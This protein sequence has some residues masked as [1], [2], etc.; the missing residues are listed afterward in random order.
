MNTRK[1]VFIMGVLMFATLV[2]LG[3]YAAWYPTRAINA[4]IEFTNKTAERGAILFARN[5]RLCHGD[6]GEG[7]AAGARMPAAPALN[8]IDL[9]G[10]V[11]IEATLASDITARDSTIE[12][13]NGARLAVGL[14]I[15][16]DDE[17]MQISSVNGNTLRVK[18]GWDHT[19]PASHFAGAEV[20]LQDRDTLKD[21]I[22]LLTNT[23]AC[24]R[25]GTAMPAWAQQHGGPLSDEQIRQLVTLITK[26][27]WDMVEKEIEHEDETNVRLLNDVSEDTISLRVADVGQFS[28]D[29]VIRIG[30]ERMRITGVPRISSDETDRSGVIQV[31]RGAIQSSPQQHA[32][33]SLIFRFPEAPTEPTLLQRSC[34]Q[35][36]R[37]AAPPGRPELIEPFEGQTVEIVAQNIAFNTREIRVQANGQVRLRLDNRDQDI[38]HNIAVRRS[39]TDSTPAS[40]GSVGVIF[41]G[42]AVGDVAF[43]IPP[44]GSYFFVC[45]VHPTTMTGTFIVE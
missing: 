10:F 24:G 6:L 35:T 37:P 26:S 11:D 43:D 8:R 4:E 13:A 21:E 45:D 16:I 34:G 39:A 5:C 27:R 3:M 36:A 18:R 33:G 15:L 38:D 17:R 28:Q 42:P 25:V 19:T 32:E 40:P 41:P 9:Q 7:G 20:L 22:E 2:I 23:I 14:T 31:E 29:E 44:P 30:D 12:I 1:Q